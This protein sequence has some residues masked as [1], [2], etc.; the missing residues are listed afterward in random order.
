[1]IWIWI[2][3]TILSDLF[4]DHE[5]SGWAKAAWVLFLVFIPFLTA[6]IYLIA[7]GEGMR[8][9]TIKAQA[10]A[11]KHFDEYVREQAGAASPA[12][13]LHKLSELKDKGALSHRGVRPGEGQ[14]ARLSSSVVPDLCSLCGH[15]SHRSQ[16][17]TVPLQRVA[18][19]DLAFPEVVAVDR[20]EL[21]QLADVGPAA[22]DRLDLVIDDLPG[23]RLPEAERRQLRCRRPAGSTGSRRG[24]GH[25][26]ARLAATAKLGADVEAGVSASRLPSQNAAWLRAW[27]SVLPTRMLKVMRPNSSRRSGRASAKRS[28]ISVGKVDVARVAGHI[29]SS[30]AGSGPR[31]PLA[32][33]HS[34]GGRSAPPGARPA[35]AP[36]RA[37]SR[38]PSDPPCGPASSPRTRPSRLDRGRPVPRTWRSA[39]RPSWRSAAFGLAPPIELP[40][41]RTCG[42]RVSATPSSTLVAASSR[43]SRSATRIF[44]RHVRVGGSLEVEGAVRSDARF[45][46][47]GEPAD[48]GR[49]GVTPGRAE[50]P[51]HDHP[52]PP[53]VGAGVGYAARDWAC[54]GCGI[55]PGCSGSS[56]SKSGIALLDSGSCDRRRS[57]PGR[58]RLRGDRP[59]LDRSRPAAR[60]RRTPH[61]ADQS[62]RRHRHGACGPAAVAGRSAVGIASAPLSADSGPL[63]K[64][65]TPTT[66]AAS[67]AAPRPMLGSPRSI[68]LKVGLLTPT[69]FA[70]SSADQRRSRRPS[71]IRAPRS[72]AAL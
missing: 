17:L 11:K 1:M 63:L 32:A 64:S 61:G 6:L 54:R 71:W 23:L 30:R 42:A 47:V 36:I 52:L 48:I 37:W 38:P 26:L 44:P 18:V 51:V 19:E 10:D 22:F 24:E 13:E 21:R 27:S 69:R 14:A 29:S 2:L 57:R 49:V 40:A 5:L 46:Q 4:R 45:Q 3:I 55:G 25:R 67:K 8:D 20:G 35:R 72:L 53:G 56:G 50:N 7:R 28:S 41:K 34:Q 70:N 66:R 43:C 31:R 58:R 62:R 68:L 59:R 16:S 65:G 15:K 39:S 12:D 60:P 9:R 33:H